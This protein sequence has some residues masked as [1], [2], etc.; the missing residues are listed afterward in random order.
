M[1]SKITKCVNYKKIEISLTR[2]FLFNQE[3]NFIWSK[4]MTQLLKALLLQKT[5]I[6]VNPH[7]S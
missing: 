4:D 2:F 3:N 5:S 1:G 7:G 6:L